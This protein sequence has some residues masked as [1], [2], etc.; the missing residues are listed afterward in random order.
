[1]VETAFCLLFG[2]AILLKGFWGLLNDHK[3]KEYPTVEAT[4]SDASILND[5]GIKIKLIY[6]Y[7]VNNT[8]YTF[9]QTAK[10]MF[11]NVS[12]V[13]T[14]SAEAKVKIYTENK[15]SIKL[16]Y[17]PNN[18]KMARTEIGFDM[19]TIAVMVFGLAF[20]ILGLRLLIFD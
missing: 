5:D 1:M 14:S 2:G 20:F 18:P 15:E 9:H 7:K 13:S 19:I 8:D 3:S 11:G 6:K 12:I 10:D 17:D 4:F 16:Y